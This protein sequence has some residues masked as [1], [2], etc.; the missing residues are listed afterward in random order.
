[1][2]RQA[3]RLDEDLSHAAWFRVLRGRRRDVAESDQAF[4]GRPGTGEAATWREVAS[5]ASTET[6]AAREF[7]SSRRVCSRSSSKGVAIGSG[8]GSFGRFFRARSRCVEECI[9][10]GTARYAGHASFDTTEELP[11]VCREEG[12]EDHEPPR[13]TVSGD[14]VVGGRTGSIG[15]SEE[16]SRKV[17]VLHHHLQITPTKC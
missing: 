14:E 15:T 17:R 2:V 4:T 5:T 16:R 8:S 3:W 7:S 1:M 13:R 9:A 6:T 12:E 10:E 11:V